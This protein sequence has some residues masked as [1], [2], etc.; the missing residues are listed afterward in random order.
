[1]QARFTHVS[2]KEWQRHRRIDAR[3]F[4][5]GGPGCARLALAHRRAGGVEGSADAH[6]RARQ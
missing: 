4:R 5:A 2:E 6:E 1:M 3:R